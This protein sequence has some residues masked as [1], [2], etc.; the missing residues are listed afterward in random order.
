MLSWPKSGVTSSTFGPASPFSSPFVMKY[1]GVGGLLTSATSYLASARTEEYRRDG[2]GNSLWEGTT[3]EAGF[4]VPYTPTYM[5]NGRLRRRDGVLPPLPAN[6]QTA[7]PDSLVQTYDAFGNIS[8]R[9]R[10]IYS[11]GFPGCTQSY[12]EMDAEFYWFDSDNQIMV[13]QRDAGTPDRTTRNGTWEEYHYDPFGRRIHVR[14]RRD[15]L[16]AGTNLESAINTVVWDGSQ[17]LYEIRDPDGNGG[18]PRRYGTLGYIHGR[19]LDAPLAY[20]DGTMPVPDWRGL[21]QGSVLT[22][23]PGADCATGGGGNPCVSINWP[24]A[25][26]AMN[27]R[28]WANGQ[29]PTQ[30]TWKGSLTTSMRDGTGL[31]YR[32]NRYYDPLTG[33]FTQLDPIGVAGGS[34]GYGFVGGD[35]VNSS[36]PFGLKADTLEVTPAA[37][38]SVDECKA[39]SKTCKR[40]VEILDRSN[41]VWTVDVGAPGSCYPY[42]VGCTSG[43]PGV[44][45]TVTIIPGEFRRSA[46]RLGLP[47]NSTIALGHEFG[48]ALTDR[49]AACNVPVGE[50]CAK[51]HENAVRADLG[52]THFRP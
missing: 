29:G 11:G 35:P 23:G 40:E 26:V 38:S 28:G 22:S 42:V 24:A 5:V 49:F 17:I 46:R 44:G 41:E 20:T 8:M 36:D 13:V 32:R 50:L 3:G 48:H 9:F 34:N 21:Y 52:L 7:Y 37:K 15:S 2:L 51:Q 18:P 47:V 30:D 12:N 1:D 43:T 16:A 4:P 14:E 10:A 39:K 45:G 25:N 19:E 33:R 6:C 31:L 27:F